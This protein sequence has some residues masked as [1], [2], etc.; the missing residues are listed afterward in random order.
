MDQSKRVLFVD[1]DDD[2]AEAMA[3]RCRDL[4]LS[5]MTA[6]NVLT[7]LAITERWR[8]DVVCF[9]IEMPTGNG[10][11]VCQFLATDAGLSHVSFVV[12]SGH[13]N[14]EV[15][16]RCSE[17]RAHYIAKSPDTWRQLESVFYKMMPELKSVPTAAAATN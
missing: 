16:R 9:D 5:V 15:V 10:L 11:D 7:A 6:K 4:G 2:Y 12:I 8:P 3:A 13:S 14:R 1:D 17:L